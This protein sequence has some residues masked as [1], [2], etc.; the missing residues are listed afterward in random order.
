MKN[1]EKHFKICKNAEIKSFSADEVIYSNIINS[2]ENFVLLKGSVNL[3]K[4]EISE[5]S[6]LINVIN[7][8]IELH[9]DT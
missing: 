4:R 8:N 2:N 3:Y 1:K 6:Q 7:P 5:E 9:K